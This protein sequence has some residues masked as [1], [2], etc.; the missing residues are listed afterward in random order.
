MPKLLAAIGAGEARLILVYE[1]VIL[2]AVSAREDGTADSALVRLDA[3][4]AAI[5]RHQSRRRGEATRRVA[6]SALK[7]V[8]R[9]IALLADLVDQNQGHLALLLAR[10]DEFRLA[11]GL[12]RHEGLQVGLWLGS[13]QSHVWF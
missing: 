1:H 7:I 11:L 6:N 10:A 2:E 9:W 8:A 4:V 5:V 3:G 12:G 13:P